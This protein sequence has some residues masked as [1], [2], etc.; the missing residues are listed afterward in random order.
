MGHVTQSEECPSYQREVVGA[1]PI[2]STIQNTF[3]KNVFCIVK[4]YLK[5]KKY[6]NKWIYYI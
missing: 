6:S 3:K 5:I 2:V 4:K 1:S